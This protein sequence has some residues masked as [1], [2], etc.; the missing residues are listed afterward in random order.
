MITIRNKTK[1]KKINQKMN[2]V[3]EFRNLNESDENI[4]EGYAVV[5]DSPTVLY[6]IDGVE[7]KE[8]ISRNAL[9]EANLK[10]VCLKYNHGD[11]A[12]ILA[13]TRNNSLTLSIDEYGLK[14]RAELPNTTSANDIYELVK[15]GL[16]DKCS[17]A[18][19]CEE[20]IY[21][22]KTHTRTITKIKRLYD[23][24]VVDIPAYDDTNVEARNFF[25][26]FAKV[27]KADE[28]LRKRLILRTYC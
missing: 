2:R 15:S 28:T 26:G 12:Y 16:I 1:M 7:Y 25:D 13:R 18:F 20:D 23:V 17:F 27:E 21:D 22:K 24:S 3:V 10:D 6:E 19:R 14:F 5:F 4:L 11:S 8:I 9:D